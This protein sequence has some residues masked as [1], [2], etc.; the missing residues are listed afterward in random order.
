MVTYFVVG[1]LPCVV[2]YFQLTRGPGEWIDAYLRVG[3]QVLV[4]R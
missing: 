4:S 1:L 2:V 3:Q